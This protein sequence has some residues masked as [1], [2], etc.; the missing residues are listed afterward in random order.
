[1]NEFNSTKKSAV[2][3]KKTMEMKRCGDI[4]LQNEGAYLILTRNRV[5]MCNPTEGSLRV[6][7]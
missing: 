7:K 2:L 5:N 6:E 4:H 3:K 1:M